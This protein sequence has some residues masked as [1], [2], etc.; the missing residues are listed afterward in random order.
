MNIKVQSPWEGRGE[1]ERRGQKRKRTGWNGGG[2]G[3]SFWALHEQWR[4]AVGQA[5]GSILMELSADV[6]GCGCAADW[7]G[8][9]DDLSRKPSEVTGLRR[10]AKEVILAALSLPP[11]LQITFTWCYSKTRN[12]AARWSGHKYA[13]IDTQTSPWNS[14]H[15]LTRCY[16]VRFNGLISSIFVLLKGFSRFWG[17]LWAEFVI[18]LFAP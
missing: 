18:S 7:Q 8:E 16:T 10:P 17:E 5:I 4:R 11:R 12:C 1:E 3:G 6:F 2:G 14:P 13:L 15:V 9:I